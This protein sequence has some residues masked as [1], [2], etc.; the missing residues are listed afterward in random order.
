MRAIRGIARHPQNDPYTRSW[1]RG[2]QGACDRHLRELLPGWGIQL[3]L[4]KETKELM[5]SRRSLVAPLPGQGVQPKDVIVRS[6][7]SPT[8]GRQLR[9]AGH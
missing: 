9:I 7:A 4:D 2:V 1:T 3:S 8:K 6:T 5:W